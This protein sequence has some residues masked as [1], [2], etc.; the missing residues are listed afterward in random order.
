MTW[1]SYRD[2]Y[3]LLLPSVLHQDETKP[4]PKVDLIQF[5]YQY[6]RMFLP[7]FTGC[8]EGSLQRG[9]QIHVTKRLKQRLGLAFLFER[10]IKLNQ[11]YFSDDPNLLPYTLFHEMVHLW[12]YD[13]HLDPGHTQRFYNKMKE[14]ERT[15]LPIDES[16]HIHS[17]VAKEGKY[18][19]YCPN[20][21]NRWYHAEQLDYDIF[22]GHCYDKLGV[23]HFA[24]QRRYVSITDSDNAA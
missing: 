14:F 17:R 4:I 21:R 3:G 18:V 22:C 8:P 10:T 24:V 2:E 19:Y 5:A 13:C 12:L 6:Y 1:M 11:D 15:E 7:F 23:E 16:V 9:V 20:C